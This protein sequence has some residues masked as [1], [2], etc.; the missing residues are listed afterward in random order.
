METH[1]SES[2][3]TP[4][5]SYEDL[6]ARLEASNRNID[7]IR[8]QQQ[9]LLRLQETAKKHLEEMDKVR[10]QAKTNGVSTTTAPIYE[11]VEEV[12]ND[13]SSLVDRMKNLT[14]FIHGQHELS[15]LLGDDGDEEEMKEQEKLLEKL[16]A[17][18]SHRDEM[19]NLITELNNVNKAASS[20]VEPTPS[21]PEPISI[22][23]PTTVVEYER[24][25][26]IQL[27]GPGKKQQNNAQPST[28]TPITKPTANPEQITKAE[29][30]IAAT[31]DLIK[32]K[33]TDISSMKNQLKYLKDMMETIKI[34]EA[35]TEGSVKDIGVEKQNSREE[36]P[37]RRSE[38]TETVVSAD[39]EG[40]DEQRISNKVRLLTEVTNELR[41]QSMTLTNERDRIKGLKEEIMR[42]KN[43]QEA[44]SKINKETEL[45]R[46]EYEEQKKEFEKIV[47]RLNSQDDE[48][49]TLRNDSDGENDIPN[50]NIGKESIDSGAADVNNQTSASLD[51]TASFKSGS[52]RSYSMPPPMIPLNTTRDSQRRFRKQ[53]G[54]DNLS[55]YE[56]YVGNAGHQTLSSAP[57]TGPCYLY[58]TPYSPQFL[59][60]NIGN[61]SA[62]GEIPGFNF[63]LLNEQAQ[64]STN[65]SLQQLYQTQQLLI[66]SIT[67]CNNMIWQ[68]QKEINQLNNVIISVSFFKYYI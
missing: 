6:H 61:T 48:N 15:A 50:Q 3:G 8:N 43:E 24:V 25:V 31:N 35:K 51:A 47:R 30:E 40:N 14:T 1:G 29:E 26:P 46:A 36:S 11:S 54:M 33:M 55:N 28:S 38:S 58:N 20:S 45:L 4:T 44:Q 39:V 67:Q 19:K 60:N 42:R 18:R 12:H 17:L 41:Q 49:A 16:N 37:L 62:S 52:S 22:T 23:V 27:V 65:I 66:N 10:N 53:S 63:A 21:A 13:M 34:I 59:G 56:G 57:S 5:P 9:H 7:N 32:Q 64:G 68:Q 2:H